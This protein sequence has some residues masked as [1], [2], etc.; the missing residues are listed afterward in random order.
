MVNW[1]PK[2][3]TV[4]CG[5]SGSRLPA[6][7]PQN[8]GLR[9]SSLFSKA[10]TGLLLR[11]K[12]YAK[13]YSD[14]M[15]KKYPVNLFCVGS[16]WALVKQKKCSNWMILKNLLPPNSHCIRRLNSVCFETA[17]QPIGTREHRETPDSCRSW[18]QVGACVSQVRVPAK[19]SRKGALMREG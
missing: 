3:N 17:W 8:R 7:S 4:M 9:T 6:P 10:S 19:A 13:V 12:L 15:R 5:W 2:P 14:S 18:P 16:T 11:T 1:R